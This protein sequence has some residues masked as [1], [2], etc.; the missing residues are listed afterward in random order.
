M[1]IKFGKSIQSQLIIVIIGVTIILSVIFAYLGIIYN[2]RQLEK[3]VEVNLSEKIEIA[4]QAFERP[5]WDYDIELIESISKAFLSEKS[6]I[7][8]NIT[9]AHMKTLV[10][11]NEKEETPSRYLIL[12]SEK[13]F[14]DER[15]LGQITLG[16]SIEDA[17][18]KIYSDGFT[19]MGISLLQATIICIILLILSLRITKPLIE[20]EEIVHEI[21]DGHYNNTIE[22]NGNDEIK[23]FAQSLVTLQNRLIEQKS[24]IESQIKELEDKN[25][26]IAQNNDEIIALY[27][28]SEAMNKELEHLMSVIKEDYKATVMALANSI[29]ASDL[30]TRGHC[31]RVRHYSCEIAKVLNLSFEDIEVLEYAAVLHDIGKIG[32]SIEVLNKPGKLT[33]EEYVLVKNHPKIGFDIVK[34][35]PFLKK[36]AVIMLQHHERIDGKGYP[37][38][39]KDQEIEI[40]AKILSV[41][42]AYDAMTSQ[43]P[44]RKTPLSQSEAIEE[45]R[46]YSNVAYDEEIVQCFV[47]ILKSE[48]N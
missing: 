30:Y 33:D 3:D 19:T 45:L 47:E 38:G 26:L 34:D 16:M 36:A 23:K 18:M 39:L 25:S 1:K 4:T 42:D 15:Y 20:M 11:L 8:I 43:R 21:A 41:A 31:E 48:N 29:E 22:V 5:I 40:L 46:K 17:V 28:Q 44:Y 9:D 2:V 10:Y 32:I 35:V 27:E 6:T 24:N 37:D 7:S 12:K 14:L 13:I